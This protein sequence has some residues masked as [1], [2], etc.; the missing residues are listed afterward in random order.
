[1]HKARRTSFNPP[2]DS[3]CLL[4]QIVKEKLVFPSGTAT[5]QLIAVLH[6]QPSPAAP[7]ATRQRRGYRPLTVHDRR[8]DSDDD[9][10]SAAFDVDEFDGEEQGV[11]LESMGDS[12]WRALGFSFAASSALT[13]SSSTDVAATA[14]LMLIDFCRA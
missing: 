1:L 3:D 8:D 13:V 14:L 10:D 12:G 4:R 7:S 6:S 2:P 11:E 5:A 9:D